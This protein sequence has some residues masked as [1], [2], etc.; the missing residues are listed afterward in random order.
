[1]IADSPILI[2]DYEP[3][4]DVYKVIPPIIPSGFEYEFVTASGLL[5]EVQ[6]AKKENLLSMILNFSVLSEEFDHEYPVTNRGEIYSVIATVIEILHLFHVQHPYTISYEFSGE[7]KDNNDTQIASIRTRLY[8]R[9][10]QRYIN[11]KWIS[12]IA[13]NRVIIRKKRA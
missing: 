6:F 2:P 12:E 4:A 8:L 1:M 7:H 11:N 9:F 3:F 5:Y 10:A 13:C